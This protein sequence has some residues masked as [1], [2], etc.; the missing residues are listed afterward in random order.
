VLIDPLLPAPL[1]EVV[2][3]SDPGLLEQTVFAQAGLFALQVGWAS[4]RNMEA[5]PS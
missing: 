1:A 5:S 4:P 3:G 2:F